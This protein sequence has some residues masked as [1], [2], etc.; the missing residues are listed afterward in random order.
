MSRSC[1]LLAAVLGLGLTGCPGSVSTDGIDG[2]TVASAHWL[3]LVEGTT[4]SHALIAGSVGSYCGKR[5]TAE[6]N[7]QQAFDQHQERLDGGT[8]LCE[9][10]D[11]Y[12]DDLAQ[13]FNPIEKPGASYLTVVLA[14][15]VESQD[16]DAITAPAAGHYQQLGG[17]SD[18]TF[19]ANLAYHEAKWNQQWA[20]A[21]SCED[22]SEAD[23]DDAVVLGQLLAQVTAE[24]DFPQ[25]YSL[26]AAELDIEEPSEDKRKVTVDGDI[27]E[28]TTTIGGFNADFTASKCEVQLADQID[29]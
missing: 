11:T 29:L 21:W 19:A 13:A 17:T 27:L 12:Y 25:T 5:Q 7:R 23:M 6:S 16:V 4:R 26:S 15:D 20:D 18:G 22:L 24:V 3:V 1:L 8:P 28:G 2:F 14:R 9:S 10:L